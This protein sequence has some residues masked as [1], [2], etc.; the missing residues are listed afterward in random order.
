VALWPAGATPDLIA[1]WNA[2]AKGEWDKLQ[3]EDE[4]EW[5]RR[6]VRETLWYPSALRPVETPQPISKEV[7]HVA[8]K[9][10]DD[11]YRQSLTQAAKQK[12]IEAEHAAAK[13][14]LSPNDVSKH[15][16]QWGTP[17]DEKKHIAYPSYRFH[18]SEP[19]RLVKDAQDDIRLKFDDPSWRDTPY[20]E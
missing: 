17:S 11:A 9:A 19:M 12:K 1:R 10:Y 2:E 5:L 4:F 6:R 3:M 18:R 7:A 16:R 20:Y 14:K 13:A 15:M 8:S